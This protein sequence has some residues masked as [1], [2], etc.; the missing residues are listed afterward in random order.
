MKYFLHLA[1]KG[2]HYRGWQRQPKAVSIQQRLEETL[3]KVCR[4]P[5]LCSSCGRTDAGVHASQF[6]C[7]FKTEADLPDQLVN[8]L[9]RQLPSDIRVYELINVAPTAHAQNDAIHRTYDYH[10]H[11]QVDPFLSELST[12]W[13]VAEPLWAEMQE[14]VKLLQGEQ[15]FRAFCKQADLYKHTTCQ[16]QEATLSIHPSGHRMRFRITADRF[17]RAMVRLLVGNLLEIGAG[18]LTVT[19]F[20]DS[21]EHGSPL[22]HYKAAYPQGLY[23]AKVGYPYLQRKASTVLDWTK[24]MEGSNCDEPAN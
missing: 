10:C 13:P 19:Q 4:Q 3:Q 20:R 6:F 2:T 16:V 7:H 14:A 22:P 24:T 9:N 21:L 15:D 17:L 11:L 8:L 23:L 1:Y 18:R 12:Y 5:L